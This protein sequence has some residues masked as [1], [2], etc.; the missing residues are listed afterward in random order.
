M[1]RVRKSGSDG[2]KKPKLYEIASPRAGSSITIASWPNR[3]K[4]ISPGCIVITPTRV[5]AAAGVATRDTSSHS[6]NAPSHRRATSGVTVDAH[7]QRMQSP[8]VG[9]RDAEAETAQRQFLAG[10][11]QVPDRGGDQAAD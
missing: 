1:K 7:V 3:S 10:L 5:A 9:A 11:G 4:N 2:S 8:C 6:I